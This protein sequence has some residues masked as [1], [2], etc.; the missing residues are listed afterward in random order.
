MKWQQISHYWPAYADAA[1][2]RWPELD[3]D[4]FI[5]LDGNRAAFNAYL[6]QTFGLTPREAEEQ[7]EDWIRGPMPLDAVASPFRDQASISESAGHIPEGEDVY[8]EDGDFGDDRLAEPPV[9][10]TSSR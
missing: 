6:G 1:K 4:E 2:A 3:R 5:A 7:I 9:G 10:R 8:S